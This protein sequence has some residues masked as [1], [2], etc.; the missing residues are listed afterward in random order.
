MKYD[1]ADNA[2][3]KFIR[4][5]DSDENGI[6]VCITCRT[7]RHWSE[8]T[9]GHYIK[10]RHLATRWD[11]EN[12]AAQCYEC[13]QRAE[14]DPGF[15]EGHAKAMMQ[16]FGFGVIARLSVKKNIHIKMTQAEADE[17]AREYRERVRE[18]ED[19]S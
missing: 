2:F 7:R 19:A 18:L 9:C 11:E 1:S 12:A 3:S 13:Q 6:C 14:G 8:M 17:I 4:L 5:R 15:F 16:R 10:R